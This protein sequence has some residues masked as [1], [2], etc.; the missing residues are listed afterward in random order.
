[1]K[2]YMKPKFLEQIGR[3]QLSRLLEKFQADF[4]ANNITLPPDTLEER[5]FYTALGKLS[6]GEPG[7]PDNCCEAL[8][9]V[10]AM[11]NPYARARLLKAVALAGITIERIQTATD[12]DVAVQVLLADPGLFGLKH[13]ESRIAAM[14]SFEYHGCAEPVD[15]RE[16][17]A[18]TTM[19]ELL[20]IKTDID[21]WL[22]EERDGEEHVTEIERHEMDGEHWFLIRRGDSSVRLPTVEGRIITVRH[23]RLARDVV[24]VLNLERDELRVYAKTAGEKRMLRELF[25]RRLFGDPDHFSVQKSFTLNPLRDDLR[26]A[27][28]VTRGQGIDEIVLVYLEEQLDGEHNV[29]IQ[30]K[31][32]DMSAYVGS[33]RPW[34]VPLRGRLLTAGFLITFTGNP[35]KPRMV[36]VRAGNKLRLTRHCDAAAVHRW[37]S[38]KGFRDVEAETVNR[39]TQY[40]GIAVGNN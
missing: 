26:E 16:T 14:S 38:E 39:L 34:A 19:E 9:S 23:L 20:R 12:A 5:D 6:V 17:F 28:T 4:T 25:G 27:L 22:E 36:Y 18:A 10:E 35:S 2:R 29:T 30:W 32:E 11:A 21:T 37:L 24:V 15:R 31:L 33:P 7:L 8:F 13:D 1:M 3:G 40:D